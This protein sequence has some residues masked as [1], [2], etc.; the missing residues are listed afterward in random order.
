MRS[1]FFGYRR[2]AQAGVS[3]LEVTVGLALL[4]VL[5]VAAVRLQERAAQTNT[6]QLESD[7][8]ERADGSILA[9][10]VRNAR[11]PCPSPSNSGLED[12]GSGSG[13]VPWKTIGLPD[14]SAAALTYKVGGGGRHMR[15]PEPVDVF[16]LEGRSFSSV[17]FSG[18]DKIIQR[19]AA[20]G[21]SNASDA[22]IA[23]EIHSPLK[24]DQDPA[25]AEPASNSAI[26]AVRTASNL[27]QTLHCGAL[28]GSAARAHKTTAVA[29]QMMHIA[30]TQQREM[31][32]IR[33][34]AAI[35]ATVY[36]GLNLATQTLRMPAKFI[37]ADMPCVNL[38]SAVTDAAAGTADELQVTALANAAIFCGAG[39][40]DLLVHVGYLV[41]RALLLDMAVEKLTGSNAVALQGRR[42]EDDRLS[43]LAPRVRD[44]ANESLVQGLFLS[45]VSNP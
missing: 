36:A 25:S 3:I 12:C 16:E 14:A 17:Q 33:N 15:E 29:A 7:L 37:A 1:L 9:Y 30:A 31:A 44:R 26:G 24:S 41:N 43:A 28:V 2:A 27:W 13:Y 35:S 18:G 19:C 22:S 21:R 42:D 6:A 34:E 5:T 11:L 23:Y 4:G 45:P 38:Q 39:V 8:V 32:E 20:L 10:L 40:V